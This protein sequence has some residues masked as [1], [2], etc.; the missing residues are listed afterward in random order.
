MAEVLS[1]AK[2]TSVAGLVEAG[3]LESKRGKVRLLRPEELPADWD[4][5]N[6][7][8]ER[9]GN[10]PLPCSRARWR[11]KRGGGFGRRSR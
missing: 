1:K 6:D 5:A 7:S 8:Y 9:V 2:V 10:R 11:R 4:S 3:I